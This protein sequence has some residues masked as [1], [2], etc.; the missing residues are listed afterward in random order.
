MPD[1]FEV[2]LDRSNGITTNNIYRTFYTSNLDITL[3][4]TK[5]GDFTFSGEY[6][7][8]GG[9]NNLD[10]KNIKIIELTTI[11]ITCPTCPENEEWSE[12]LLEKQKRNTYVCSEETNFVCNSTEEIRE[13]QAD[14]IGTQN[15]TPEAQKGFFKKIGNAFK[16]A[17]TSIE[18]F[19]KNIWDW[20]IFWK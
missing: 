7:Q 15:P 2:V 20:I 4:P 3:R 11:E 13:C 19:F 9:V 8:G 1:G 14:T 16:S 17:G 18:N 5:S 6:T 12:C 10:N